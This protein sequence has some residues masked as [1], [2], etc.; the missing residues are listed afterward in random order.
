VAASYDPFDW[1]CDHVVEKEYTDVVACS[2]LDCSATDKWA[3]TV[4]DCGVQGVIEHCYFDGLNGC[5][6]TVSGNKLTQECR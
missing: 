2:D 1:N 6:Q 4:P 5:V 3:G